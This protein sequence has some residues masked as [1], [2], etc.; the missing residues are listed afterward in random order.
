M[1]TKFPGAN[2]LL[3]TFSYCHNFV[4]KR[5]PILN[6]Q[7]HSLTRLTK[8][9]LPDKS[10]ITLDFYH[11]RVAA[12]R[13]D[14]RTSPWWRQWP[15]K[16]KCWYVGRGQHRNHRVWR[17]TMVKLVMWSLSTLLTKFKCVYLFACMS[18]SDATVSLPGVTC[19]GT[20]RPYTSWGTHSRHENNQVSPLP[21]PP[22]CTPNH[23]FT[24][25]GTSYGMQ[26]RY[27]LF[28]AEF[29][30]CFLE[31]TRKFQTKSVFSLFNIKHREVL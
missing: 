11:G 23:C 2:E 18:V 29:L 6:D 1:V 17:F 12:G 14:E 22:I 30:N 13:T 10:C 15:E 19:Q 24:H 28:V 3:W 5:W 9:I 21:R 31:L 20:T 16:R 4:L 25:S 26:H 7:Q 8:H 27:I